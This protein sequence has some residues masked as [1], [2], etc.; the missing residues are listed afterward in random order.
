M[1]TLISTPDY[2]VTKDNDTITIQ[3][4]SVEKSEHVNCGLR[5]ALTISD[6]VYGLKD[7][8]YTPDLQSYW[9]TCMGINNYVG[10][11]F[12]LFYLK[13]S[14]DQKKE[15]ALTYLMYDMLDYLAN[16]YYKL[17]ELIRFAYPEIKKDI[18]DC[19]ST[20]ELLF[21]KIVEY[22][23]KRCF[24]VM[25]ENSYV[26][27]LPSEM[28][29]YSEELSKEPHQIDWKKVKEFTPNYARNKD[30]PICEVIAAVNKATAKGKNRKIA[31]LSEQYNL[32]MKYYWEYVKKFTK[33]RTN[34]GTVQKTL[35]CK[36]GVFEK[37]SY[38]RTVT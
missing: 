36:N 38:G 33:A 14:P 20:A 24:E 12:L 16:R 3:I 10:E 9:N 11:S 32:A 27:Y 30:H 6:C 18:I 21:F 2:S 19:P 15:D 1:S 37:N 13:V 8:P 28:S 4:N 17:W 7:L 29:K 34:K 25:V 22:E 23:R 31:Y 5:I 35:V 26:E